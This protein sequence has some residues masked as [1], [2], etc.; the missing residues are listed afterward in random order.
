MYTDKNKFDEKAN[1]F[2]ALLFGE[3]TT[4]QAKNFVANW[5]NLRA[6]PEPGTQP[7]KH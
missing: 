3:D 2:C 1:D 7:G 4:F 5:Y 6:R